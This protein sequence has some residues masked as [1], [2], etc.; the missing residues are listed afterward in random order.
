M[1]TKM[2]TTFLSSLK[3]HRFKVTLVIREKFLKRF[4][5]VS[6]FENC[7]VCAA[8]TEVDSECV[9]PDFTS[10]PVKDIFKKMVRKN[11]K[12]IEAGIQL[13]YLC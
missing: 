12:N 9:S 3:R 6:V 2:S 5:S 11:L 13:F 1:N 8:K 7:V 10:A 4:Q